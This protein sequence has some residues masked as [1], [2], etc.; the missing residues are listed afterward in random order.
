MI[1]PG[2]AAWSVECGAWVVASASSTGSHHQ[3]CEDTALAHFPLSGGLHLCVADGVSRGD[4]GHVA[5]QSLARH[6]VGMADVAAL[7]A[8]AVARWVEAA[9][10]VVANAVTDCGHQRGAACMASAWLDARG[11]GCLSHVGDCRIYQWSM[12]DD[13]EIEVVALTCDQSYLEL[14][15]IPPLGVD[16]RNPARMVGSGCVGVAQVQE[17]RLDSRS[18]LLLCSDGVH[19]VMGVAEMAII[20]QSELSGHSRPNHD[21]LQ[22]VAQTMAMQA[23]SAGSADD[24]CVA[25]VWRRGLTL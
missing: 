15:E 7:D 19:D 12:S 18:G 20:F 4:I 1:A 24:I 21:A 5:A 16:L 14:G 25:L 6:C 3:R 9:D 10:V 11:D 22:N 17:H 23:L 13:A 8:L 2:P